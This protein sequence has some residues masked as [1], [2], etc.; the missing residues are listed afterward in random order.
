MQTI[1]HVVEIATCS[2]KRSTFLVASN[3]NRFRE[4][5]ASKLSAFMIVWSPRCNFASA[6]AEHPALQIVRDLFEAK[7]LVDPV[8]VAIAAALEGGE[9]AGEKWVGP[10]RG[11]PAGVVND[12]KSTKGF[13]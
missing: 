1:L 12:A 13:D 7:A 6:T 11:D 4:S 8:V 2:L 10:A 9:K 3:P 5:V